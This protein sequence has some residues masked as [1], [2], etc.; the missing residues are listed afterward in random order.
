MELSVKSSSAKE[1]KVGHPINPDTVQE[2]LHSFSQRQSG[3]IDSTRSAGLS[4]R[5][6]YSLK[7]ANK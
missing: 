3:S 2:N 7:R 1:A 5:C 6:D 4:L